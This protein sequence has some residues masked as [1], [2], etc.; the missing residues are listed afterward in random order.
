MPKNVTEDTDP[1]L[2]QRVRESNALLGDSAPSPS[3]PPAPKT[4]MK[5]DKVKAGPYGS[6]PGEKRIDVGDMVKPLGSYKHGTDY[7]PKTGPAILHQGEAVI[8]AKDN[9]MADKSVYSKINE[10]GDKPKKSLKEIRVRKAKDG[11]HII[12]HHHHHPAHKMEE[13]TA[14]DA[15]ALQAHMAEN[16]PNLQPEQPEEG[17]PAGGAQAGAPP[18]GAPGAGAPPAGM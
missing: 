5:V 15:A 12:E 11:T 10:G 14:K 2:R 3:A 8:P 6:K 1:G 7:V 9:K 18:M 17:A 16:A 4:P 13:H